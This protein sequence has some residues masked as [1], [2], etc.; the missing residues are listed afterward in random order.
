MIKNNDRFYIQ[1][2]KMIRIKNIYNFN[3]I[4]LDCELIQTFK[5]KLNYL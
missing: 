4:G 3:Y 1:P 2:L 5:E